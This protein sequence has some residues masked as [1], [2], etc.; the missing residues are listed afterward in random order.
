MFRCIAA[1]PNTGGNCVEYFYPDTKEGRASAEQF[2][3]QHNREGW[4]VYDCVSPLR[5]ERRSKD[6]VAQIVGL[7]W[8]LDARQL[9]EDK[10]EIIERV[11][12][13][14]ESFGIL[15]RL[16]DSGRGV[17]IY[18]TF[19]EPVE[20]GTVGAERAHRLL[21]QMA[22]HLGADMAPTHFAALMRRPGTMNSKE[23]G[24]PCEVLADTGKRCSLSDVEAYLELVEANGSL[25]SAHEEPAQG[26][27]RID[28]PVDVEAELA[29]M[30]YGDTSGAGVNATH[31]R[32]IPSLIWKAWAPSDIAKLVIDATMQIAER[33]GLKWDRDA[34]EWQVNAR[35]AASYHNLFEKEYDPTT[36]VIPVW[37][38]ME[39][40]TQWANVLADGRRP[41]IMRN[42]AGWHVRRKQEGERTANGG[43][44]SN[45]GAGG[46]EENT[47]EEKESGTSAAPFVLRPFVAFDPAKL[48]PRQFL[49][50]KH[51][52]R[53]T[54]GGTVAPGGTGKS[55]LEMVEGVSMATCRNLLGEQPLERLR[56]WYHNGED[57]MDELN[58]RLAAICQYYN[59]PLKDLEGWF[60]MTS[61][62]EVPLRV[63]QGY[64]NL[65]ID[66]RLVKCITE[67]IGDNRIDVATFDPLVTLH[68][69][70]END[71]GKMDTVIRLFA[72]IADTQDCAI[73]LSHHT[74]KLLAGSTADYVVDDMR[75]AG[76]LKDA[77]RAVRMLNF[78]PKTEAESAGI[79]ELE[80]TSYFRVDRVKANNAPPAKCAIWRK[81][82][83]VDLPNSDEVGVIVPWEFPGQDAPP[84]PEKA[85]AER[86]AEHIF[87]EL[88]ARFTLAGRVVNDRPGP[89]NA[90]SL[91]SKEREAKL[92]KV[93]KAALAEAM[94]R[95]FEAGKI[96]SEAYGIPS[97]PQ[98]KLVAC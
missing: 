22:E 45:G 64:S 43:N 73:E 97:R 76:S 89:S 6:T 58:R 80:R 71:T 52:Q 7:H 51:Y 15:S 83:N 96:K 42:G 10:Q 3:R 8:D 44:G 87:L 93:G 26:T 13:K 31:C 40:H 75:G 81:F 90:A 88:L 19:N 69:V 9:K 74:R 53:R 36:G 79:A 25:F 32:V 57:N 5:E 98:F 16:T 49:F 46:E 54:T 61:G 70:P 85:E 95:L 35:I 34:E 33:S 11:R 23:G 91:F 82:V 39:L 17:H 21:R 60:F 14:L 12:T 72:S 84:S 67:A 4:G 62:N 24:G 56:V 78:M 41:T 1:I 68:G 59:I 29:A 20:P 50:G 94:R 38:P 27:E 77:M 66:H 2:A 55:T 63:A 86:K 18:S 37:L 47:K 28:G 30:K 92:A 48:K 65:L